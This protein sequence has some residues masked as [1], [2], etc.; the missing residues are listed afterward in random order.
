MTSPTPLPQLPPFPAKPHTCSPHFSA[1]V[2]LLS[3]LLSE[4]I[5]T[6]R[7]SQRPP[8]SDPVGEF[9]VANRSAHSLCLQTVHPLVMIMLLCLSP[10]V[11]RGHCIHL[12]LIHG[13]SCPSVFI[14]LGLFVCLWTVALLEFSLSP[15]TPRFILF[16]LSS[17]M[18]HLHVQLHTPVIFAKVT[19]N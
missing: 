16:G 17:Q 14:Q 18:T 5:I 15:L 12:M 9:T 1:S 6:P 11:P 2:Y 13:V 19:S 7:Q 8:L 10:W 3:P 4:L